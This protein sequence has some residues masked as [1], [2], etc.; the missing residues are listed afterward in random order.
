MHLKSCRAW[1]TKALPHE[2]QQP[3]PP[4]VWPV[5]LSRTCI[6]NFLQRNGGTTF[7][8]DDCSNTAAVCSKSG[9]SAKTITTALIIGGPYAPFMFTIGAPHAVSRST[10]T[11]TLSTTLSFPRSAAPCGLPPTPPRRVYGQPPIWT[12]ERLGAAA[13]ANMP[14]CAA[15][16]RPTAAEMT[17]SSSPSEAPSRIASRRLTSLAPNRHTCAAPPSSHR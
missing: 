2:C 9:N 12:M 6:A 10:N 13:I 4:S 14:A 17:A 8:N 16:L 11:F 5:A 7:G 15:L 1:P 3:L